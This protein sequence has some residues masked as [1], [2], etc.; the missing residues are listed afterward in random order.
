MGRHRG[1]RT[2]PPNTFLSKPTSTQKGIPN[3]KIDHASRVNR[4]GDKGREQV[5][6]TFLEITSRCAEN[7]TFRRL[8]VCA[9]L[10]I[11]L[12]VLGVEC[13]RNEGLTILNA[14]F[15]F[16]LFM[17]SL[18]HIFLGLR[19]SENSQKNVLVLRGGRK[20][21]IEPTDL[22]V[23]DVVEVGAGDIIKADGILIKGDRLFVDEAA[24][25][26]DMAEVRK[27]PPVNYD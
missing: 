27:I 3:D 7:N 1:L 4:Y 25:T 18:N 22:L 9:L 23:E 26:G 12:E 24:L 21:Q 5:R 11:L 10:L 19:N 14:I 17:S 15:L 16:T 2:T 20:L 6:K 8:S 13:A